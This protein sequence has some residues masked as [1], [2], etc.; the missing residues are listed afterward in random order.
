[1][2][3]MSAYAYGQFNTQV[4]NRPIVWAQLFIIF[5]F[6]SAGVLLLLLLYDVFDKKTTLYLNYHIFYLRILRCE[7]GKNISKM[8]LI[9][10]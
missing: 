9:N 5:I 3:S 8:L 2:R 6:T 1:M 7:N 4:K 10:Y